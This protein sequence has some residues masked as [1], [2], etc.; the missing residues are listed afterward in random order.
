MRKNFDIPAIR[1]RLA[2]KTGKTYWRSLDEIAETEE[3]QDLLKHEFPAGADQWLNPVGRRGFLKLMG[4]SLALGG[5]TACSSFDLEKIVPYVEQPEAVIPGGKPLFF[6][7][8]MQLA[9][10][11]VGLLAE[12]HQGRPTKLE[13]NP[14]HPASLGA[15]SAI[16]QATILDLYDPDRSQEI[17]QNGSPDT[18]DN[19]LIALN[20]QL[21]GGAGLRIL[22]ETI[23]SPSLA[24][25][26]QTVLDK[27]PQAQWHQ[28][29]PLNTDNDRRGAL[30]A[31]GQEVNPV[32]NFA[33]ADVILSLDND[34]MGTGPAAVRYAR[35]FS[36]KRRVREQN[37]AMNRLYMVE[38]TPTVTGG[39]ADHRLALRPSQ[40][41]PFVQALAA[42][43]GL[44][45]AAPANLPD[46]PEK[47]LSALAEDLQTNAGRSLAVAGHNQLPEVQAV[48]HAINQ[49]LGNAGQ[50]VNYTEPLSANSVD[51]TESLKALVNDMNAGQVDTLLIIDTN[52]VYNAPADFNFADALSKVG[53]TARLG[54]HA[55]E[56]S[57]QCQWHIPARH[58]LESWAD[59]RAFDGTITMVQPLIEPLYPQSKSPYQL[60]SAMLGQ[61]DVTNY[62]LVR[63]YWAGEVSADFETFWKQT[64]HDGFMANSVL[65]PVVVSVDTATIKTAVEAVEVS[66]A[67]LEIDFRSDP[68]M[69]DGRYANNG[70]LQELPKPH[71]K[72]TWDNAAYVSPSTAEKLGVTTGDVIK[73]QLNGRAVDAPVWI[74]PGQANDAISL[75]LGYGRTQAGQVGNN[76]GVN[77]YLLR[78]SD[79]LWA[80]SGLSATKTGQTYTLATTQNHF[81]MEDRDPVQVGTLAQFTAEPDFVHHDEHIPA[82]L[83]LMPQYNYTGHSWGMVVDLSVCN[84]CNACVTA[85]QSE[86]NIPIVGKEQVIRGREMHW[87]RVD[88][89]FDGDIDAP[90]AYHQPVMCQHCEQAPCEVVC[91]VGATNHDHEGL[92]VMV[93][94]RC[95]GT[96]YC[97]NNCPY[98]VRRYNFLQFVDNT[99][100][101]F[102]MQ[103]NPDVTV[104]TRGV[105]EK[106]TYCV[107]RISEARIKAKNGNGTIADGEVVTACQAACP[108]H[109]IVFGN[110]NDPDSEVS[111]AKE[112][113]HNYGLLTETGTRPR[114]TYLAR[115]SNP[116]PM[117]VEHES[118]EG[119]H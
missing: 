81:L 50:T 107:Q 100:E 68:S 53:F 30:L 108:M 104:R 117:L 26:L 70:W 98:K 25:L 22:T 65:S 83:T 82:E 34:F 2:G 36:N 4:A 105:M 95:I 106:C 13:G 114:T 91:P 31:F 101:Q 42:R 69:W 102:K 52:P 10:V 6:A 112:E 72:L 14:Q 12:S 3:F 97:S 35:D 71:N 84:G 9:G 39:I 15:T 5:L 44:D 77:A 32:Y 96:R 99:T 43:L 58:Y 90:Q 80:A 46:V 40:M 61:P 37:A 113:P 63:D 45:M 115:L 89:Y 55:D 110:I 1:E 19:F 67:G 66:P 94:N 74:M 56:T 49:A 51:Q 109:A 62:D 86:N 8:A 119:T 29:E 21:S 92:N 7:T 79:T 85:C 47:W 28:Y 24:A 111:H 23:T 75:S 20:A 116:H 18:W 27:Y 38:T 76:V 87:I 54:M 17:T 60:F 103:R 64:R 78:A 93:Y 73:L 88:T 59:A 57:V 33:Q 11:A 118:E 48:V 16:G 41:L